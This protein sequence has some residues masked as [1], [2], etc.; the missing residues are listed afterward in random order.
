MTIISN[1]FDHELFYQ[2]LKE[3]VVEIIAKKIALY[4]ILN[5][6]PDVIQRREALNDLITLYSMGE[7]P[8]MAL[9]VMA[10]D[11]SLENNIEEGMERFYTSTG[12]TEVIG[13]TPTVLMMETLEDLA[14]TIQPRF[15][16]NDFVRFVN[17]QGL[18][19][20]DLD[21]IKA[22]PGDQAMIAVI[23]SILLVIKSEILIVEFSNSAQTKPRRG[24]ASD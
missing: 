21:L 5:E 10:E 13:V 14:Y 24:K 4:N 12:N 16:N 18:R 3:V 2:K 23:V 20:E 22:I 11:Y 1:D 19:A 6:Q 15:N 8:I 17:N 9:N 7:S